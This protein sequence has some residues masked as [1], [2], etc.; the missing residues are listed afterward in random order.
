MENK[1]KTFFQVTNL[2]KSLSG[3]NSE[4]LKKNIS[5]VKVISEEFDDL[6]HKTWKRLMNREIILHEQLEAIILLNSIIIILL[7]YFY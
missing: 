1:S 2:I 7:S 4:E 6:L 5:K 3:E